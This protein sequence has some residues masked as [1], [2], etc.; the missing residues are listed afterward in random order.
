MEQ[1][2]AAAAD[3]DDFVGDYD[4]NKTW[5]HLSV[6]PYSLVTLMSFQE[7]EGQHFLLRIVSMKTV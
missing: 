3:D 5:R 2:A 6:S 7:I 1:H 4:Q